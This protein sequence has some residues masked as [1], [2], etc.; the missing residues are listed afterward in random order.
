MG[1]RGSLKNTAKNVIKGSQSQK[2]MMDHHG[3]TKGTGEMDIVLTVCQ[4]DLRG[5]NHV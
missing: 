5:V 3:S 2:Y 1:M 4:R